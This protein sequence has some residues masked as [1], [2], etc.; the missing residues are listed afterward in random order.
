MGHPWGICFVYNHVT[1]AQGQC[2]LFAVHDGEKVLPIDIYNNYNDTRF[3]RPKP[4]PILK[5]IC[6]CTN[7]VDYIAGLRQG[8]EDTSVCVE[9]RVEE[10]YN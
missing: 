4:V 10:K 9:C 2:L 6:Q 3:S 1:I 7:R 5:E 8:E